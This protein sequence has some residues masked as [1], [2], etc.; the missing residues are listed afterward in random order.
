M[1][2]SAPSAHTADLNVLI[3]GAGPTGLVLA[4]ILSRYG[5]AVRLIEKRATL[6]RHTK[7]TNLMQRTQELLDSIDILAPLH[8]IGGAM[9]ALTVSAYGTSVGPRTMHLTESAFPDV[10]LCGQDALEAQ[11]AAGLASLGVRVE[12]GV[13]LIGLDQDAGGCTAQILAGGVRES[14]RADYVIGTDGIA[15]ATR[16]FT[17]LD[18]TP[19]RTG[20]AI[21]QV[22]AT[23]R[24]HRSSTMD[25]MW[26]FYFDHGFSA[27]VPLPGGVHRV[28]LVEPKDAFPQREPTLAEM[29]D[30]LRM[31]TDDHTLELSQQRWS[32]Y[33]DLA[34]GIAPA[35][36][37][38]RVI[39]A[40]DAGNPILPN[41]GQGMN[42][43]IGDAFNLGWKLAA[44]LRHGATP[45]LLATYDTERHQL[46]TKMQRAQY[47]SLKYTTLV[48]PRPVRAAFRL[49]AGPVLDAGAEYKI[50]RAFSELTI[51]TRRSPLTLD[52]MHTRGTRAG[53]R[54]RDA[55]VVQGFDTVRLRDL[56][57]DGGWTLLAFS[58]RGR[59]A[60]VAA[61]S[62]ALRH[63]SLRVDHYLVTTTAPTETTV[64]VLY[65]LDGEAHRN[66]RIT[67]PTM[68]LIRP[69]GY[70]AARVAPRH[71]H[72]IDQYLTQWS[73][74]VS[75][76]FTKPATV[77]ALPTSGSADRISGAPP[78]HLDVL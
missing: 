35:L 40:G 63:L 16:S 32:S 66:Y 21:R 78:A 17:S 22:D 5:V 65:D 37:D 39:L 31:V 64:D 11:A 8:R 58:G 62:A 71:L 26:M 69:D 72:R 9:S 54:A 33:T 27:V 13:E 18:F 14:I 59:R 53:D 61:T 2:T 4:N 57:Y 76:R 55:A 28:I 52:T 70:I 46:R 67:R 43:G 24:W 23:L 7:A 36:I 29:Q 25:Q 6:S 3:V 41:G 10:I 68:L 47:N 44:V 74:D 75:Q 50:A 77:N 42:T 45:E 19:K 34:M 48:T 73:P 56:I 38:G 30:K 12:F 1:S 15:G 60:D 49:L 51:T 20:V